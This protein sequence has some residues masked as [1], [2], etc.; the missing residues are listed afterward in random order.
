MVN[1]TLGISSGSFYRLTLPLSP[2]P[3]TFFHLPL[4][5]EVIFL[6]L[7]LWV[8][9][10]GWL[11]C[12]KILLS[13]YYVLDT[14]LNIQGSK[15][16][17]FS[18]AIEHEWGK[19]RKRKLEDLGTDYVVHLHFLNSRIFKPLQSQFCPIHLMKR[20]L[21]KISRGPPNYQ[22]QWEVFYPHLQ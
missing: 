2:T 13:D 5:V 7:P 19:K 8:R 17:Q 11:S 22:I 10:G 20:T 14:A 1:T 4:Q 21:M 18:I 3:M 12:N 16:E 9:G 15:W 6:Q